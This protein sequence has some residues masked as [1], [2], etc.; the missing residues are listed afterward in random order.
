M[1][2]YGTRD[3][4]VDCLR[5]NG[6]PGSKSQMDK[7]CMPSC[8][9]GPPVA[10]WWGRRPIYHL[11]EG[12]AWARARARPARISG[13]IEAVLNA[14]EFGTESGDATSTATMAAN[15]AAIT[16]VSDQTTSERGARSADGRTPLGPGA[17]N[18]RDHRTRGGR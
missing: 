13:P 17:A 11:D 5:E 7:L 16:P 14:G 15:S 2:T 18:E 1:A 8:G 6:F 9:D 4:L 3:Q 10:Y 12:L